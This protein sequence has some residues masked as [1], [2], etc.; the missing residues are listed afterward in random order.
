MK[1]AIVSGLTRRHV[2]GQG[3]ALPWRQIKD[4]LPNFKQLTENKTVIMGLNTYLS[5]G[6]PLPDRINIIISREPAEIEGCVVCTSIPEALARAREYG[7]D[8]FIIGGASIYEQMLPLVNTMHLSFIKKDYPGD[9]Y[10]PKF[11]KAEWQQTA[12]KEFDEFTFVT[13]ERK[14]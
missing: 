4:D 7:K 1:V 8:T 5:I 12:E 2:I 11:S 6:K 3:D 9:K 14:K 13:L 10:F